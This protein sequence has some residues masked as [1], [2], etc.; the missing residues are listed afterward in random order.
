M[1]Q[2]IAYTQVGGNPTYLDLGETSIKATYSSKEIQDVTQQKSDFTHNITLPF[3]Q[4]NNDFFAHYYEVN[5]DGSFRADIKAECSIYVDSNSQFEGYLQLVNVD[6]LNE[7]YTVIAFGDV[8]N[9]ATELGEDKL[10]DLDL[11]KYNHILSKANIEA[12]WNG[13]TD[14]V[15]ALPDGDEILYPIIDNGANYNGTNLDTVSGAIKPRDLKPAIKVRTLLGEIITKAGYTINSTFLDS[16]F[17]TKQYMTLGG[18]LEGSATSSLDGFKVGLDADQNPVAG[19]VEVIEFDNETAGSGYYD[20]NGNFNATT[21]SYT[22]PSNGGYIISTQLVARVNTYITNVTSNFRLYRNGVAITG[23]SS[24]QIS[25]LAG[26]PDVYNKEYSSVNLNAGDIITLRGEIGSGVDLTIFDT[27]TING[28]VYDSFVKLVSAPD[29]VEGGTVDFSAGNNL[30][31]QD[32]QVDFL[33]AI[34]SRYNLIVE[35][36]KNKANQLNIEPTQDY[37]DAG[38]S[39]D[40]TDKLDLSKSIVIEPT[41]RFRKAELNLTDKEDED[42]VNAYWQTN[43]GEVYNSFKFPFYGDFGSGELKIPTIFSSFAPKK[44]TN[45]RMFIAQH[46]EFED[47]EA[48]ATKVKPKLFY[49]SGKKQLPPSSNYQ[50]LNEVTGSTTTKTEYPFCHHYSMAG[51]LV[52]S[53]DTD[54]RFKAGNVLEQSSLVETQTGNDVYNDYWAKY[55]NNIYSKDARIQTAYFYLT[56]E[57]IAEFKYSDKIFIK[58]SYWHINKISSYAMG[59]DN[60]TKVELIKVLDSPNFENCS[61]TVTSY[62]LNGTT[63]WIDDTGAS[64]PPTAACCEAEGLTMIGSNC[65]WNSIVNPSELI[66][67][68]ILYDGLNTDSVV[69]GQ[70]VADIKTG[71]SETETEF[72]GD[73][74]KIGESS[75]KEAYTLAWDDTLKKADWRLVPDT[76]AKT[77][78]IRVTSAEYQALSISSITLLPSSGIGFVNVPISIMIFA[79]RT[80]TETSGK[81]IFIGDGN[82]TVAGNYFTTSRGFMNGETGDRSYVLTPKNGEIAQGNMENRRL[83]LYADGTLNGD[84]ELT[85][86]VTYQLLPL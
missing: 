63:N 62:N 75:P 71:N 16:T 31:P 9:V 46:F 39:K 20:T 43:K 17:F 38:I 65:I 13:L 45:N 86:Y 6:T 35:K 26:S 4:V 42:R 29:S 69:V 66:E 47:G 36:D 68:P 51:T 78:V 24:L 33:K 14:Y 19:S 48:K 61:L 81:S 82:S 70:Y 10:N 44:L 80:T 55:L 11:S 21:H 84:I 54:I 79:N 40:W 83:N 27:E 34:F 56:T 1:V 49:Y 37:R 22:V 25:A 59:V 72:N 76:G 3:S 28:T 60:S 50:L 64:T 77:E 41:N 67:P 52:T 7:N 15:G 23:L 5:I 53:T 74:K 30:L 57:D 18:E 73:I 58:D 85:V 2:L 12:G 32:K 8:A